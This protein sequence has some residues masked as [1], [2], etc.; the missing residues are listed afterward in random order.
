M[1]MDDFT[2]LKQFS[3]HQYP[4][5]PL[6]DPWTLAVRDVSVKRRDALDHPTPVRSAP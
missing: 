1:D 5:T 6:A 3:N 4:V 2:P